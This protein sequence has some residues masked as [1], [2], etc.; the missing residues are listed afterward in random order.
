[1]T[2]FGKRNKAEPIDDRLPLPMSAG[3]KER[4]RKIQNDF[5]KSG[6]GSLHGWTRERIAK[7]L[8]EAEAYLKSHSQAG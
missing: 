1:M 3:Q 6:L 5:D 4:Y 7:L 8:D 2:D